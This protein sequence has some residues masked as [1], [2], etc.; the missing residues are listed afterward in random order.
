MNPMILRKLH[1]LLINS[2]QC[3][4]HRQLQPKID[5]ANEY[6]IRDQPLVFFRSNGGRHLH[7]GRET[8]NFTHSEGGG[9]KIKRILTEGVRSFAS[10]NI[11]VNVREGTKISS[12]IRYCLPNPS[13]QTIYDPSLRK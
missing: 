10:Q 12:N 6:F 2:V 4:N 11:Y 8:Q 5:S 1:K 13:L 9:R 7:G 3:I